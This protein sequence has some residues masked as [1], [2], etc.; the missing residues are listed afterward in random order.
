MTLKFHMKSSSSLKI[1]INC[2]H[3]EQQQF[4]FQLNFQK[5]STPALTKYHFLNSD[6]A[7]QDNERLQ[8]REGK[9]SAS[10]SS[11]GSVYYFV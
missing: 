8:Y 1:S 9:L 5:F 11:N 3:F 6:G 4:N 2:I 7:V 10:I